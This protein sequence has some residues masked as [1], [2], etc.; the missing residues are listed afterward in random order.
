MNRQQITIWFIAVVFAG[1]WGC[2]PNAQLPDQTQEATT[3]ASVE[4]VVPNAF[5]SEQSQD[6]TTTPEDDTIGAIRD[7]LNRFDNL[8]R[9]PMPER[10]RAVAVLAQH[11][12]DAVAEIE[13]QIIDGEVNLGYG[14]GHNVVRVLEAINSEKSRALLRRMALGEFG[15][16]NEAWAARR[17][18]AC[19][20]SEASNLLTS[21]NSE[22]L[23]DAIIAMRGQP[24]DEKLLALLKKSLSHKEHRTRCLAAQTLTA[25][26]SGE[27]AIEALY[28][29]GVAMNTVADMPEIDVLSRQRDG[30]ESTLGERHYL[31][32]VRALAKAQVEDN[33]IHELT[34]Q[35]HGRA[36]DS[37]FLALAR[38]GDKSVWEEMIR[39]IQDE[40]A[41]L[42]RSW[43]ARALGDIGTYED[44]SFL[45]TLAENDPLLRTM[46]GMGGG[47]TYPVR[48]AAKSA[49]RAIEERELTNM[50]ADN[51]PEGTMKT[52]L[53]GNRE[54]DNAIEQLCVTIAKAGVKHSVTEEVRQQI[55]NYQKAKGEDLCK[56]LR[57]MYDGWGWY[58]GP[59]VVTVQILRE[60]GTPQAAAVLKGIALNPGENALALGRLAVEAFLELET[61]VEQIIELLDSDI[62]NVYLPAWRALRGKE[63]TEVTVR[64]LALYLDSN[65]SDVHNQVATTFSHDFVRCNGG[66]KSGL[67]PCGSA[68]T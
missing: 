68:A 1:A 6:S 10:D 19:D 54:L 27:L 43:A 45:R 17:L 21:T 32:Y 9:E 61:D 64:R 39:L 52:S 15:K 2:A 26:T 63:L 22:V 62:S 53:T 34:N 18:I 33:M 24:I 60:Q 16:G 66:S 13:R 59:R 48:N 51:I 46:G 67:T 3:D 37:A 20:R 23:V 7:M 65:V 58:Y 4:E 49:I 31:D 44:W 8:W 11:G 38:R 29:I 47:P 40:H 35:L 41:G 28:A 5:P 57:E 14:W 30:L 42:F 12:D 50:S 55:V 36:K 25:G 56:F